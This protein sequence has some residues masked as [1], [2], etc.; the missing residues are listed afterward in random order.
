MEPTRPGI[1]TVVLENPLARSV[2]AAGS[3]ALGAAE[4][5]R[6]AFVSKPG[7]STAYTL[8]AVAWIF[9]LISM[10]PVQWYAF[11]TEPVLGVKASGYVT[12][13]SL[14]VCYDSTQGENR[15]SRSFVRDARGGVASRPDFALHTS[16][17]MGMQAGS[18]LRRRRRAR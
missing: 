16:S 7:Q 1:K 13:L 10:L 4:Q 17:P 9:T 14:Y 5:T 2:K 12:Q 3:A 11:A 8:A 18:S 6:S 15:P